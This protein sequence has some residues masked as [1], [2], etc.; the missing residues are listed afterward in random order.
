[1]LSKNYFQFIIEKGINLQK[2]QP[3]E[4]VCSSYLNNFIQELKHACLEYGASS[5]YIRHIDGKEVQSKI[6]EGYSKYIDDDILYYKNLIM[7]NFCRITVQSPFLPKMILSDDKIMEYQKEIIKLFFV[8][9]YFLS[10][11]SQHTVCLAVNSCWAAKLHCTEENLWDK[12]IDISI[13]PKK[14]D[15]YISWMNSLDI[16]K[17]KFN[18]ALGTCLEVTLIPNSHLQG[19]E[20]STKDNVI[21]QPNIPCNEI[22]IAPDKYG[23]NGKMVSSKPLVYRGYMVSSYKIEFKNG[24]LISLGN[25]EDILIKLSDD[26]LYY[27]GEISI[28]L[29]DP[30]HYYSTL[31]DENMGCHLALGAAYSYGSSNPDRINTSKHHMDLI[32]GTDDTN[33]I[34]ITRDKKEIP[35]MLEGKFCYEE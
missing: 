18:T 24:K 7:N 9:D 15:L 5:V 26:G 22:Y 29:Y 35:I 4:I 1:M 27:V 34:A 16:E 17:L 19:R 6:Q 28:A 2:N 13:H 21:F 25:L 31:L 23:V 14:T 12:I 3:V 8:Q 10:L 32:F 20:Q 33:V 30:Q 11:Q